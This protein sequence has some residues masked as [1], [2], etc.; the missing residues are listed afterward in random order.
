VVKKPS[1]FTVETFLPSVQGSG[2]SLQD[3]C[4]YMP[5]ANAFFYIPCR[6]LWPGSNIDKRLPRVPALTKGG[7]PKCGKYGNPITV[8]PTKWIVDH[9]SVEQTTWCP[10]LPLFI[11]D[12]LCVSGGWIE[13]KGTQSFNQYRPPQI[14]AGD[15]GKAG[16]WLEHLHWVWNANDAEHCIRW[17]AQRVQRPGEKINHGLVLGGLQG[18][19][20]DSFLE[21]VKHAVGNWNFQDISPAQLLGSFNGFAKATILRINEGR[22]LGE[23]DR[24][25]FYDHAKIYT[26]APPDVL[27][28]N[29]KHLREYYIPNCLG[30]IITTNHKTDG[31]FLP[32]DD[33][34]HYVAWSDRRKEDFPSGYWNELWGWYEAGGFEHVSAYLSALDI[35]DFDPKAPPRKTQAFWDIVNVSQAP[36]DA[37]L[38]DVLDKMQNPDAVT[39][40][41]LIA[42]LQEKPPSG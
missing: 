35:S 7:K 14:K 39:P 23:I 31:I 27:R 8:S 21:P 30:L 25:K 2:V 20:K 6:E 5:Q 33:R 1:T 9:C 10:G 3:F 24:F 37:E 16:P 42:R 41:Q 36:E 17:C 38:A 18:I 28:I 34:R 12:R 13:R 11:P 26:A 29:E 40:K 4:A 19:G 15:P 22:D 32:A